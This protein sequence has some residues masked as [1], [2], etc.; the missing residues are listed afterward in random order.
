[1]KV[2]HSLSVWVV[3]SAALGALLGA[4]PLVPRF[5]AETP[6]AG[7]QAPPSAPRGRGVVGAPELDHPANAGADLTPASP[8]VALRPEEQAKTFWLPPGYRMEAVLADPIIEDPGQIAFDG[9]GR[10]F[11]VELRGYFQT[12]DGIDLVPPGG[13]ISL[14]EDR[15]RDGVYERHSVF[16]DKLV[17]PRFVLPFG[18]G[19]ILTM[20]TNADEVWKYSDTDGDGVADRREL[21]TAGFGRAGTM[22]IQPSSLFWAMDNWLYSTVNAYRVRWTP[23]GVLR[24]PTAPN[25]AQWGVSQDNHGKLYFQ[26]GSSGLPGYFQF[27]IRYGNFGAPDQLE[28]NLNVLWGAPILTGDIQQ[29]LP[30]TRQP[31]GSLIYATASAGSEIYRGDRLPPDLVGDY[32]YGEVVGRIVRRLRPV[33]DGGL[34]QL[35]N[36]HPRSEFIRSIDPL[37]RPVD[38]ATGPDGAIYIADMYRGIIEGAQWAKEGTYLRA[39]IQQHGL[40]KVVN[41]RGRIWRLSYDGL[42]HDRTRPRMLDQRPGELVR[43]LAHPNGWWRDTAQ[44]LIVLSQDRSVAPALERMLRTS[45][46]PLARIHALWTLE[47]LGALEAPLVRD[48]L[49]D[50]DPAIRAAAIRASET[51]YKAGERSL[52]ADYLA[53]TEDTDGDVVIQALLTLNILKAPDTARAASSV[54]ERQPA[55]GVAFVANRVLNPPAAGRGGGTGL[56]AADRATLERGATAY[57]ELC[58]TCHGEDG[59]GTPAPGGA[60]G[61]TVAPSLAG[62]PRVSGHRDY[63]IKVILHG[64]T[65][66]IDE[67]TYSQVMIPMGA[68]RDEWIADVSSFVRNS[69]GNTAG[70]VTPADVARVRA[71]T[72]ARRTPWTVA[73]LDRTLPRPL[74][75]DA[76]WQVSASHD[77]QPAS[78]SA[79]AAGGFNFNVSAA[80]AVSYLGWTTGVPQQ[81]GMWLQVEL[82]APATVTEIQFTS[83]SAGGGRGGPAISTHP[84]GYRVQVSM[85]G[86]SWSPPVA[87]GEGMPGVTTITFTPVAARFVR[88]TQT[89]DVADAPPWSMRLLRLFEVSTSN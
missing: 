30:H 12:L 58:F 13:R 61:A 32:L 56:S 85:D 1:M 74:A 40:D 84:R 69:F 22:E 43:H 34:T 17:F 55:R 16:V 70:F 27:P 15:D 78:R 86:T 63:V 71:A 38:V 73:E 82:P 52:A 28:P 5:H 49:R 79:N 83:S 80:G 76:R 72:A 31:D 14:H 65:G 2:G 81:A 33:K 54:L 53:L 18:A 75:P 20:E 11:V 25:G 48:V 45:R 68:N 36:V 67:R 4:G 47:G 66:P 89:A 21:F 39:K 64:L 7:A 59:T 42:A 35:R 44:R 46:N 9:N 88:I 3:A 41:G 37:F 19:A 23:H 24:E 51:L 6:Q 10:M 62:S 57:Q 87:E 60:A 26:G 29:G 8:V 50:T 77:G